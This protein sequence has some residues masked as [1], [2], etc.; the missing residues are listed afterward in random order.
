MLYRLVDLREG[1]RE[2]RAR[3]GV[4]SGVLGGNRLWLANALRTIVW[5]G[6]FHLGAC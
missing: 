3:D 5:M 1:T 2:G 6:R 4:E